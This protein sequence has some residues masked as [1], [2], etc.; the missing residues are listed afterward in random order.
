M[1]WLFAAATTNGEAPLRMSSRV[2]TAGRSSFAAKGALAALTRN[3]AHVPRYDRIRVTGRKLG[4]A[5]TPN[6]HG[7]RTSVMPRGEDRLAAAQRQRPFGRIIKPDQVAGL[8][9]FIP[10]SASGLITGSVIDTD[11]NV[12]GAYD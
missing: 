6:E 10:S 9:V 2:V 12:I 11:R 1:V 7:V 4:W 8:V 3:A 5:D